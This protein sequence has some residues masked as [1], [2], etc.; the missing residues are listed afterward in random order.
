MTGAALGAE[1]R[2][3]FLMKKD[4]GKLTGKT[5]RTI[6]QRTPLLVKRKKNRSFVLE[7][8]F[9]SLRLLLVAVIVL[10]CAGL[11]LVYG[12]AKTYMDSTPALEVS[13]LT[14]SDRTSYIYDS[15]GTEI[16][17]LASM[18]YREWADIENIPDMLKNA[19]ISIED[20]RFY[21]H[22]GVDFKRLFSA[23]LEILG[24]S[25]SSGGSTI[26][27][28]LIKNKILGTERNYK[29]KAQEA[30]LAV[31][32]EK[33]VEKDEILEAY[34]NDIYLGGSDYGVVAAARD[35]F[36]KELSELTVRECALLAGITQSPYYYNPR[37]N[38][39]TRGGDAYAR[40]RS[41]TDTVLERMYK[42][43]YITREQYENAL[44]EQEQ[45]VEVSENAQMYDYAYFVEYAV[46]DVITY[47]MKQNGVEDTTANRTAYENKLR[48]GGY[49]IYTTLDTNIQSTVQ[50]T[51]A[52]WKDYPE[53]ADSDAS[54]VTEEI[55]DTITL[56]TIQPQAAAVVIKQS[57][58]DLVAIIGGRNEPQIR[59]G[60]NRAY[61]SYTEVGSAIKP[62]AVY[63]P[64]LDTGM[65]PAS[66]VV[67]AEGA[68]EGWDTETGYPNGGLTN[69]K[70]YGFVNLRT[71]LAQSLNVVAARLLM[72]YVGIDT[73]LE[74]MERLG[75]PARQLNRNGAGLALGTSGI[76]PIQ[77]C[78]AYAAIANNG[79]YQVPLSF[80]RVVDEQGNIILDAARIRGG[81]TRVYR[82]SSTPYQLIELMKEAVNT[83][84]GKQAK[85]EGYEV[86]GKTGTNSH[87]SSVYFAGS[88][89]DYTSVVFIGHDH[90]ANKLKTGSSGGDYA[91]A[92]WKAYME[93]IMSGRPSRAIIEEDTSSLGM[94]QCSVCPISGKLAT[95]ACRAHEQLGSKFKIVTDWFD[96]ESVPREYCDMHALMTICRVT[97][98]RASAS[99]DPED[100]EETVKVL[101]RKNSQFYSLSDDVLR[102]IFGDAFVRTEK[103][104]DAFLA[105]YPVCTQ[106]VNF[107][108][109]R[110]EADALCEEVSDYIFGYDEMPENYMEEL[111][112][113]MQAV[114]RADEYADLYEAH[115]DLQM[116]YSVIRQRMGD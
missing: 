80:S 53:L 49:R 100:T 89:C 94:V 45:I 82:K 86:A 77:M 85:I 88:T 90:P 66:V 104:V 2:R 20:V 37:L 32:L 17:S 29:R 31:E 8:L 58:G 10:G 7:V 41:R 54:V 4:T 78:A 15:E 93:Q 3:R 98:C 44:L 33:Y 65:S 108:D 71:G 76:T 47:W 52:N 92:L 14:K 64:A 75:I 73:S 50:N 107:G 39:Y 59:K 28:Q 36:G 106:N 99:C 72:E 74:Y 12:V 22:N 109:L 97:N 35:Y 30:Y 42:N 19:F 110:S 69:K 27:Q 25:N 103:S 114:Q 18:E 63:G 96:Y 24:N 55:S 105:E 83:G 102:Q 16:T 26:T 111:E 81:S 68:I 113:T 56:Q 61:Q 79:Y 116:N 115:S 112:E 5:A 67:N 21:K 46:Y 9:T 48:T 40:T 38:M 43:G 13:Q 51:L 101:I 34:L 11:G 95:P 23:A 91:A 84:T 87:Y 6:V 62:L 60:L 1:D 70:Y 57:T